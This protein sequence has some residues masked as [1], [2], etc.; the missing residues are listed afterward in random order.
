MHTTNKSLYQNEICKW[1][2]TLLK[3]V[4]WIISFVLASFAPR[5]QIDMFSFIQCRVEK[6]KNKFEHNSK[7]SIVFLVVLFEIKL[8]RKLF[9]PQKIELVRVFDWEVESNAKSYP[10]NSHLSGTISSTQH[11]TWSFQ[12]KVSFIYRFFEVKILLQLFIFNVWCSLE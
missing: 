6:V 1:L 11:I 10:S 7:V 4:F 12:P 9:S 3:F 8:R 2:C 5:L